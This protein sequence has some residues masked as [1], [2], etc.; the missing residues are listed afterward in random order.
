MECKSCVP[1]TVLSL[2]MSSKCLAAPGESLL[3]VGI[4]SPTDLN[5][6]SSEGSNPI[7]PSQRM[8]K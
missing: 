8:P 3:W 4:S 1:E 2:W 7:K 5:L 6:N